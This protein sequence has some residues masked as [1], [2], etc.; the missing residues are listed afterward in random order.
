MDTALNAAMK[1]HKHL[2]SIVSIQ[3]HHDIVFP[4]AYFQIKPILKN[5]KSCCSIFFYKGCK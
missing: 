4:C 5:Q 3:N 2:D 1:Q